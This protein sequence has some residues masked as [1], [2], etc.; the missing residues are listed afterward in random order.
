LHLNRHQACTPGWAAPR[1]AARTGRPS[2][3]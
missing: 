2:P 3:F 1:Q